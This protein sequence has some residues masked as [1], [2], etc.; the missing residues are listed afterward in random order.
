MI[1]QLVLEINNHDK[2]IFTYLGLINMFFFIV[3]TGMNFLII[4]FIFGIL[5]VLSLENIVIVTTQTLL[6]CNTQS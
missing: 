1:M 6:Q 2:N 4:N 3:F 5:N